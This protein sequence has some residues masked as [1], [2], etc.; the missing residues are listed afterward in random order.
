M[1]YTRLITLEAARRHRYG[2]SSFDPEGTPYD[3][4]R[5]AM[6]VAAADRVFQCSRKNGYGLN[7]LFCRQHAKKVA[8]S[9][10]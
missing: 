1:Y 6:E 2:K 10:G 7:D 4:Y 8:G 5:C 3:P 9:D